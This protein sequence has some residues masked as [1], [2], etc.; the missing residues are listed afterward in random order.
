MGIK[1][2]LV[3]GGAG[4]I[5]AH[6]V[7]SLLTHGFNVVV[8]DNLSTGK[9]EHLPPNVELIKNS[10][11]NNTALNKAFESYKP[12]AIIHFAALKAAG[13]SMTDAVSYSDVNIVGTINI[14][15]A[16]VAHQVKHIVFSSSAATYGE[17][18]YLP[19]DENHIQNP[20]N[21]YGAT[22][23]IMEQ[24]ISWYSKVYDI[25]YV[26]LR[27]FNAAGHTP[28]SALTIVEQNPQNLIPVILETAIGKR[29]IFRIFGNDYPTP[30]GTCLRDYIHVCDLAEGHSLSLKYLESHNDS[31]TLNLGTGRS[32]SVLEIYN[33]ACE[34]T[35]KE[36]PMEIVER[37]QGDPTTVYA[38]SVLAD[39]MLK[40]K[41]QYTEIREIIKHAWASYI[42]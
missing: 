30:D 17:P 27:Y 37:R 8:F 38:K 32:F 34:I 19:M 41:P 31:L 25:N 18:Q 33:V 21:Y 29:D 6:T 15:K 35:K 22:K 24:I 10:I 5:G 1:K 16:M 23:V 42:R 13:E 2:V 11:L 4:Y 12:D 20:T 9:S 39:K 26:A 40:W 14:L 36:I 7:E 28:S 3:I